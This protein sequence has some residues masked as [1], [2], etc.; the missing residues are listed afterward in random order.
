MGVCPECLMKA[1]VGSVA[2]GCEGAFALPPPEELGACFPQLEI[3]GLLGRGGMG[4]VYKARQKS[5]DRIVA[6]K[7]LPPAVGGDPAFAAR[8]A[9]EAR[10]LAK[11]NHP[12]IVTLHEFGSVPYGDSAAAGDTIY[13]FVMEFVDGVDLR[14]LLLSGRVAPR[15][16]LAIVPQICD[17][18]QYAHD[19]GI[20]HRDIKPEN[21]LLDRQGRVKVADFGVAKIVSQ[22]GL[23][24][25]TLCKTEGMSQ[26]QELTSVR[27]LMGT[28]QYMAPEQREHPSDVD[29]RADIYSLGIVFYQ[30]LT[31]EL[32][33]QT[34]E[35]PSKKVVVDVR[36]DEVVLRA[37]EKK[38]ELR[39]QQVSDVKTMCETIA[40]TQVPQVEKMW[41]SPDSGW[42]WL[43]G[44]MFG[45]TFTS[46]L[47]YRCANLSALGSLGF[48][49]CIGF[50]D[51]RLKS[52]FGFSGLFCFFGLIGLAV[53]VEMIARKKRGVTAP[54]PDQNSLLVTDF[55]QAMETGDYARA[56]NKTASCLQREFSQIAWVQD[57]EQR[58]RPLGRAVSREQLSLVWLSPHRRFE[59]T[60]RTTF[61]TQLMAKETVVCALQPDGEWRVEKYA[62][63]EPV[64]CVVAAKT[65]VSAGTPPTDAETSAREIQDRDYDLDIGDC[66]R[67]VGLWCASKRPFPALVAS[68]CRY[69]L[70]FWLAGPSRCLDQSA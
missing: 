60:S 3:L 42:G 23:G 37:L 55:W 16:A 13:F 18:L 65:T 50:A 27:T 35:P 51:P 2:P 6:L 41:Q 4:A 68:C 28:P 26:P 39:Y 47:A 67:T 54:S 53:I 48:L 1:G 31:G 46:P 10:S 21:I 17:A 15:E 52:C 11:L 56:W 19:H 69:F 30:M 7:I 43:I 38:P 57:L 22:G 33:G 9:R 64:P 66:L 25:V 40:A 61:A 29:H 34:I 70:S 63:S 58:R 44:K 5:L 62:L 24:G 36:L 45:T 12:N 59:Q 14:Q 20:V 8:F 32:P 49:A